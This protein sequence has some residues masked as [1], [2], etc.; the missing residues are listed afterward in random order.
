MMTPFD[1]KCPRCEDMRGRGVTPGQ[2]LGG[3]QTVSAPQ[4]PA[5]AAYA[6]AGPGYGIPQA[7]P[8]APAVSA[9]VPIEAMGWNWG[10]FQLT[11]FWTAAMNRWGWFAA[12]LIAHPLT[13][14]LFGMVAAIYLGVRGNELAWQSREWKSV[15][16]F[17]D[18][19]RVWNAWGKGFFIAS[20]VIFG[21]YLFMMLVAAAGGGLSS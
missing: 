7:A 19:Q 5:V 18:T 12:M 15:E 6:G 10:A 13:C 9:H 1:E 14:G 4:G 17:V 21:I 8:A 3:G 11:I 2:S 20:C 16:H